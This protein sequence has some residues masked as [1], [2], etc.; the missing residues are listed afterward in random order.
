M[1]IIVS[2]KKLAESG[3]FNLSGEKYKEPSLRTS[4][5]PLQR[6]EEVCTLEYG[7]SLPKAKRLEGPFPVVGS[8]G[9]TGFHKEFL[10]EGPAIIVGRKGSAGEV[11]WIQENC[12]PIDTT[13]WVKQTNPNE[14]DLAYLYWVLQSLNLSK[15]KGG[16]GI[17]GLNRNDVYNAHQIPLPPLEVQ[18]EIVAEIEGYQKNISLLTSGIKEEKKKIQA[19]LTRIWGEE[20][21]EKPKQ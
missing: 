14:S 5:F 3:D 10:I 20:E 9:I 1:G 6:F 12:F 19:T 15:L 8:N 21:K 11:N 2:K 17:P 7:S 18:K 16:A 4:S 13:Y